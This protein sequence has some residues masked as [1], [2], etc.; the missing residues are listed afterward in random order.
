MR[1]ASY[2]KSGPTRG[3]IWYDNGWNFFDAQ[4]QPL[5]VCCWNVN[6]FADGAAI[7]SGDPTNAKDLQGPPPL[8]T[9]SCPS[10]ARGVNLDV[11]VVGVDGYPRG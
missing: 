10:A 1:T 3:N 5:G 7:F 8:M 9:P 2:W 11:S 4:W 6:T